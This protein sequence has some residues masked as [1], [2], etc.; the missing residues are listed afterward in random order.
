MRR[1]SISRA[2][3]F[4][5]RLLFQGA[6][7]AAMTFAIACSKD[8]SSG[9]SCDADQDGVSGGTAVIEMTVNDTAFSVGASDAGIAEPN[10][11]IENA[12]TVTLTLTN[13]GTQ[14]HGLFIRCLPTPND[15]GCP[16]QSCFPAD[17]NIAPIAPG[18][19]TTT[20]FKVPFVEGAYTF[21]SSPAGSGNEDGGAGPIGEFVLM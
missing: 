12:T 9:D 4:D 14:P 20:T 2:R 8:S 5:G 16:A 15:R 6:A 21:S 7:I 10:I 3:W 1:Y 13:T 18:A 19:S 17:A 11:A